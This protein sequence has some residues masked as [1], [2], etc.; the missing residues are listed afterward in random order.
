MANRKI[1]DSPW[2]YFSGAGLLLIAAIASQIEV[3]LPRDLPEMPVE[4]LVELGDRDDINVLFIVFDTLRADRQDAYG[5]SR[6]TSPIKAGL[7]ADGIL[8]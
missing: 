6:T 4:S 7:A 2:F 8:Y 3:N 1:I 5:N